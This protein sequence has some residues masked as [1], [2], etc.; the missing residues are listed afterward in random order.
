MP[1]ALHMPAD[2]KKYLLVGLLNTGTHW[3]LFALVYG[4]GASQ[5][6]ANLAGFLAAV[7]LSFYLNA[8]WTFKS[9]MSGVR[10]FVM[11]GFMATLSA[12]TGYL[13]DRIMLAPVLTLV[14]FSATSLVLGY[15][16]TKYYVFKG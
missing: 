8:R 12:L 14:L 7:T 9:R 15:L 5:A 4:Q 6:V 3:G 13:A 2:F 11:L 16:F 1:F 10:Y